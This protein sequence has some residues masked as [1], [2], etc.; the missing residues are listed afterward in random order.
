MADIDQLKITII[1][2]ECIGDSACQDDAPS[3]FEVNDDGIA[4]V[5][6]GSTDDRET[7]LNAANNCPT[8]A[9]VVEDKATGEKLA[10]G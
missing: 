3:T 1:E 4:V 8:E 2:D 6:E 7:I 5:L 9:I 10:P